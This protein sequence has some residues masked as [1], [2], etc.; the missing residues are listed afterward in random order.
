MWKPMKTM[1]VIRELVNRSRFRSFFAKDTRPGSTTPPMTTASS[2][3]S[4]ALQAR[5]L[6][7]SWAALVG[8]AFV[9]GISVLAGS[10]DATKIGGK[11]A[12]DWVAV[13]RSDDLKAR[14]DA[15]VALTLFDPAARGA[16]PALIDALDD[17]RQ[18][19]RI[20]AA[21]ALRSIGPDAVAAAPALARKLRIRGPEIGIA[22]SA[23]DALVTIGP[24]ALPA[25]I[26][27]LEGDNKDARGWAMFILAGFGPAAK[28]AVP[29]LAK[30]VNLHDED[31][32]RIAIGTLGR[33]GPGASAAIPALSAAYESLKPDDEDGKLE[34]LDALPKIGSPPSPRIIKDLNDPD[35]DR[36]ASAVL[37]LSQF[38]AKARSAAGPLEALL[39]DP[40][41][42]VRVRAAVALFS[43]DPAHP[44]VLPALSSALDSSDVD[45]LDEAVPAIAKLGPKGAIVAP[46]L[47][48]I[49]ARM[50]LTSGT[51]TGNI[52]A[53]KAGATE[54][55][56]AVAP[57]SGEGV[58]ALIALL[59][60]GEDFA[61]P[62][63]LV[64]GRL[65]PRA[66]AA[67]PALVAVAGDPKRADRFKFIQALAR[68]DA[69][70]E[71]ILPALI[72]L[73]SVEPAPASTQATKSRIVEDKRDAIMTISRMG[74]R[75]LPA[76]QC[77]MRV[78]TAKSDE[79]HDSW[80]SGEKLA[81]VR[82]LGRIGP[83]AR[84]AVPFLI[85]AMRTERHPDLREQRR[86]AS[87]AGKLGSM[88]ADWSQA[89]PA[90]VDALGAMGTAASP[91]VPDLVET[92]ESE[93]YFVAMQALTSI[94]PRAQ[95][96]V[97]ALIE[98][99]NNKKPYVAARAGA[100]LLR[101]D[102]SKR[103][104]VEARLHSIPVMN[105][106]YDRAILAG[107]LGWRT[108]E[109]DGFARRFLLMIDSHLHNLVV[110]SAE[111]QLSAREEQLDLL[112][113]ELRIREEQLDNIE[114]IM[115]RLSSLG[116]GAEGAIGRLTELT[117]HPEPEVRR[118]ASETLK[119]IR[120]R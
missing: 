111:D 61:G 79:K 67:I 87:A 98:R 117:H 51:Q 48:K 86:R 25:L 26:Q 106:L 103:D 88:G 41:P 120:P 74:A 97:P 70:H 50:D 45:I 90:L 119:R 65:G 93:W 15:F 43:V 60:D 44:R 18:D 58:A 12:S 32:A 28:D 8:L 99:L 94:D 53:T 115:E 66:S 38:G 100:A 23:R 56:V 96:A 82:A 19:V 17:A 29:A 6:W 72:E 1:L 30:L 42:I 113:D 112:G 21:D 76:V 5:R 84:D 91:A 35:P 95:A 22:L 49:V 37:I 57:G 89:V 105:D 34:L 36:R 109:A 64:L 46:K 102:P 3:R 63:V 75:A 4:R 80:E 55:L 101:I 107:A 104:L 7:M 11:S 54:T 110:L 10:D 9:T 62:A 31:Q 59:K 16:V 92:L 81:A 83:A 85:E 40:S 47:K 114:D 33:I 108:P 69:G 78:L 24:A 118:L 52:F 73:A 71:A 39:D 77:L 116:T 27:C 2:S 68:I 13:L 20:K 14:S